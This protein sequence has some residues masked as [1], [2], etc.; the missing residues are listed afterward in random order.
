MLQLEKVV[1]WC[2]ELKNP[3]KSDWESLESNLPTNLR[4]M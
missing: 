3:S 1:N 2:D 4:L